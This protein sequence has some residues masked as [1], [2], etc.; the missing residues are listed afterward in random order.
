MTER[1]KIDRLFQEKFKDFEATPREEVW[2][3]IEAKLKKKK[4]RRVI[5]IWFRLSGAAAV[6][7]IGLL[8][9]RM[10][11]FETETPQPIATTPDEPKNSPDSINSNVGGKYLIPSTQESIASEANLPE[12]STTN[13]SA[14]GNSDRSDEIG[15]IKAQDAI[16][17]SESN[18]SSKGS[19]TFR[20][21]QDTE[22]AASNNQTK[23]RSGKPENRQTPNSS[24]PIPLNDPSSPLNPFTTENQL[25]L[26]PD[27]IENRKNEGES[28]AIK[29]N[30]SFENHN[31]DSNTLG[32]IADSNTK[33]KDS[34]A[35]AAPSLMEEL[36]NEKETSVAVNEQKINRWHITPNVAPI[37]LSSVSNGSPLDPILSKNDKTF[38]QSMSYGVQV[39]YAV[40]NRLSLRTG[41]NNLTLEYSTDDILFAQTPN[42]RMLQNLRPNTRGRMLQIDSKP[43][44]V[45]STFGRTI[46]QYGGSV[47]QVTGYIEVPVE[48]GYKILDRKFGIEVVGGFSTLFLNQ[49]EVEL[50][51]S[52]TEFSIGE[53]ENLSKVHFSTNIGVGFRYNFWKSFEASVE[54]ALKYQINTFSNDA[55]NFKPFF[56]GLYSGIRYKF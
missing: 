30:E 28:V 15:N 21:S 2:Q 35:Q 25:A 14:A 17:G 26:Q 38:K 4:K 23:N 10:L 51:S 24:D 45:M 50:A 32:A 12:N 7:L 18:S 34:T 13:K 37:Y 40:N 33:Q 16:A 31:T 53:A 6:L 49:N 9:G 5:P 3:N 22:I 8:A 52:G 20:S 55:G 39:S 27:K 48:A 42:A 44:H 47:N 19:K 54:P 46:T 29:T 56:F 36:L 1:K 43:A 11:F 41:L